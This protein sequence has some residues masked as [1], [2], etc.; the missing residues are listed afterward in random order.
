VLLVSDGLA[1]DLNSLVQAALVPT[2]RLGASADPI[3]AITAMLQRRRQ[4][5]QPVRELH[6]LAHG[7]GGRL[8][9]GGGV[10]RS[11]HHFGSAQQAGRMEVAA[12]GA[13]VLRAGCQW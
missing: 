9:L 3:G 13:L 1:A 12:A 6:L 2:S 4:Q 7:E 8:R 5:G 11:A 10:D